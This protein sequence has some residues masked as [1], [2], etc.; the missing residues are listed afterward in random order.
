[1]SAGLVVGL[2]TALTVM[3][4]FRSLLFGIRPVDPF[5]TIAAIVTFL[6]TEFLAA[7]LPAYSAATVDPLLALREE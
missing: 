5:V 4:L 2:A 7:S 6:I 3:M 1:M